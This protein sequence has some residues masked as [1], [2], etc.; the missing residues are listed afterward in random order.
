MINLIKTELEKALNN[1]FP[2][3]GINN[4]W[5]YAGNFYINDKKY[6]Y[7]GRPQD[8]KITCRCMD[9]ENYANHWFKM[10]IDYQESEQIITVGEC[11]G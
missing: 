1:S 3:R 4:G 10:D 5:C 8:E 9:A 6:A 11:I 2:M 7:Y